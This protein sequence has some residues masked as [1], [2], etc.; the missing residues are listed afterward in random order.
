MKSVVNNF[1]KVPMKNF[2]TTEQG[3]DLDGGN[4]ALVIGFSRDQLWGLKNTA[5]K[6]IS[7]PQLVS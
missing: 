3:L 1:D 2:W 7:E 4:G 5:F 6:G